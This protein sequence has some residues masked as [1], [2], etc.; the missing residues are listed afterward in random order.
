MDEKLTSIN[1]SDNKLWEILNNLSE[2]IQ[3]LDKDLKYLFVNKTFISQYGSNGENLI[4]KR[5]D[6]IYKDIEDTEWYKKILNSLKSN[7][8]EELTSESVVPDGRKGYFL[9]K[10]KPYDELLLILSSDISEQKQKEESIVS[11]NR[12]LKSIR[13]INQLIIRER[14]RKRL[15]NLA[16]KILTDSSL[17]RIAAI[18]LWEGKNVQHY[19]VS[20]D[21]RL[22]FELG[23]LINSHRLPECIKRSQTSNIMVICRD[24]EQLCKDCLYFANYCRGRD[25]IVLPI[26]YGIKYYG[27]LMC[28]SER[29]M[30]TGEEEL[31][32]LKEICQDIGFSIYSSDIEKEL[33]KSLRMF[34]NF[35]NYMDSIMVILDQHNNIQ[36][37]NPHIKDFG[38]DDAEL[39]GKSFLQIIISSEKDTVTKALGNIKT[40]KTEE[41]EIHLTDHHKKINTFRARGRLLTNEKSEP[42]VVFIL[43]NITERKLI[44]Q[45]MLVAQKLESV[46]RLAGGISHDFNNILSVIINYADFAI[47]ATDRQ[48]PIFDDLNKIRT[49]GLKAAALTNQLLSLSRKQISEPRL[50]D[51]NK[52]VENITEMLKRIIGENIKIDF[53]QGGNLKPVM[54]DPS[55]LDQILMN[56]IVNARDA[57]PKGGKITLATESIFLNEDYTL[58]KFN[59]KAGEYSVIIVS[60]TGI[61]MDETIMSKIFEPF[62][63]TKEPGK[64]TGLGLSTVYGL[65]RQ[66]SGDIF[67][68][69]EVEHG[70]TFKVYLPAI[71]DNKEDETRD[72]NIVSLNG[73][74][75]VLLVE[76][77]PM[78]REITARILRSSGYKVLS[79]SSPAEA[80]DLISETGEK[81][82]LLLSDIIMPQTNG[83]ELSKTLLTKIPDIKIL[84][85]SGYTEDTL[86]GLNISQSSINLIQKPFD[87]VALRKKIREVLSK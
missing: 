31:S 38:F 65:V 69:S 5:V 60:D 24:D 39:L 23:E 63:T 21:N 55:H 87:S 1:I 71:T 42:I 70:T 36:Y 86:S 59:L 83:V 3:I 84:L 19:S 49:A 2:G 25:T 85:M 81:I 20:G 28:T 37:I 12:L 30:A 79:A 56:L 16:C 32:L 33:G 47:S 64:G 50:T 8:K 29:N 6:E 77:D 27:L 73:D 26:S 11:L 67:V 40:G 34:E 48:N 78:V 76:D 52:S 7:S 43:D 22:L 9:L 66:Y 51:I 41:F 54:I 61:G 4:G 57:M 80:L 45:Q 44:E 46:G 14:D 82:D 17:F 13:N 74:E 35:M 62:F 15:I 58:R 18:L 68:Y 10:I 75:T 53:I 72:D